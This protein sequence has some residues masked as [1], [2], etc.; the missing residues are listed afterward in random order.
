MTFIST[1]VYTIVLKKQM[2]YIR[3][4]EKLFR[5]KK[6]TRIPS[7]P[8]VHTVNVRPITIRQQLTVF[9]YI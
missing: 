6:K 8:G 3:L 2:D 7:D 5:N 1:V 9:D 4:N